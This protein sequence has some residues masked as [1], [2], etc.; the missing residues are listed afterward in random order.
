MLTVVLKLA[1]F[2]FFIAS[3]VQFLED[4]KVKKC[5]FG[6]CNNLIP[7]ELLFN[8]YFCHQAFHDS[9]L[10]VENYQ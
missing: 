1:S 6:G 3:S 7:I 2:L 10:K 4:V 5:C 8:Y 9:L